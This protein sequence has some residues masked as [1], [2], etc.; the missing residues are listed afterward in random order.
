VTVS[1]P[2]IID[3]GTFQRAQE[4]LAVGRQQSKRN[5]VHPYLL[6]R[7]LK[8]S[9]G[10]TI[11]VDC[12]RSTS[13]RLHLYYF[14]PTS[15][16]R[17]PNPNCG[18]GMFDA[19]MV[20]FEAWSLLSEIVLD[21][22]TVRTK[23]EQSQAD[24]ERLNADLR[25]RLQRVEAQ[26]AKAQNKIRLLLD[27]ATENYTEEAE[28]EARAEIRGLYRQQSQETQKQLG[29][30][31]RERDRLKAQLKP[32]T[33]SDEYPESWADLHNQWRGKLEIATPAQRRELV[34]DRKML[35]SL[36]VENGVKVAYFNRVIR[37]FPET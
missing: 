28:E 7:R 32:V 4:L 15:K 20:D 33:I 21:Y 12:H 19:D 22:R 9:C 29:D 36:A 3:E 23:L 18:L 5:Q 1:V 34:E 10:R 11:Q 17:D 35:G 27:L 25:G 8:C 31:Q 14:C 16:T 26:I 24:L 30:L 2:A 37:S 13:G 6:A